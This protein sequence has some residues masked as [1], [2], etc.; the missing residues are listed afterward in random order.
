MMTM[1]MMVMMM[2]MMLLEEERR[3]ED[4]L[5]SGS[6]SRILCILAHFARISI[7]YAGNGERR[8]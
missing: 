2:F 7:L 4:R 8:R 5:S 1:R 3:M 6:I